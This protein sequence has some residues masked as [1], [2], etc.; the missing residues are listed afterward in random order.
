MIKILQINVG[1]RL[2]A[3]DLALATARKYN[4]DVL[5]ISEQNKRR[6]EEERWYSDNSNKAAIAVVNDSLA[7]DKIGPP[8]DG[9]RWIK[10]GG[11][12]FY[13]CY[14]SPNS[15]MIEYSNFIQR[16]EDSIRT[17]D[18]PIVVS[19][20]FNAHS[21][22][23]GSPKEDDRGAI[24]IDLIAANNLSV[25]NIG[26]EPTFVRQ[27][28]R[29]HIDVTFA[30]EGIMAQI[31]N[32]RVM[33]I[34]SLSLHRYISFEI[35]GREEL[36]KT[37]ANNN[38]KSIGWQF[39]K[40]DHEKLKQAILEET[41]LEK[42][43]T[44]GSL[45][46]E[47]KLYTEKM[48][49]IA[50]KCMPR[51]SKG[52]NRPPVYWWSDEI[53]ALR[54]KCIRAKRVYQHKR[55]KKN[56]SNCKMEADE[57]KTGKKNLVLAIKQAKKKCWQELCDELDKD[58]WGRPYKIVMRKLSRKRP[59]IGVEVPGRLENIIGNLFPKENNR[60]ALDYQVP[61]NEE[62]TFPCITE[63]EITEELRKLPNHKT[64]GPDGIQNELLKIV[65]Q[66]DRNNIAHIFNRCLR[67]A[68][69]PDKWKKGN[70][71]L[72]QK[73]GRNPEDSTAYRPL[74]ML[75]TI[76]KLFEKILAKRLNEHLE[77]T[78]SLANTQ[79]GFRRYKSTIDA[80][81]KVM[82]IV[83]TANQKG[84]VVGMLT[85]DVCNAFNSASWEKILIALDSMNVPAYL[86]R[87]LRS[88]LSDRSIV[89]EANGETKVFVMEKG[90]PQ[91]SV[92]G[93]VLWNIMYNDL[94][95]V[96]MP[97][98]VRLI[99]YADDVA[100]LTTAEH[101]NFLPERLEP[102]FDRINEWMK[103]NSLT[104]AEQ[105]TGAI[106]F[107]N[108]WARNKMVVR[109]GNATITS[110]KTIKYLGLIL[111]QKMN[112]IEHAN[113]IYSKVAETIRQLGYILPNLGGAKE[114]KRRL[115]GGVAMS[116]MLY[117][118]SCWEKRM[119]ETAWNKLE[120]LQ[121]RIAIRTASAYRSVSYSAI[122]VVASMPPLRLKAK[123]MTRIHEDRNAKMAKIDTI[124]EWQKLW[125]KDTN[126]RWTYT[127]IPNIEKWV[128]RRHGE[129][130]YYLTQFITGHGSFGHYLHRIGRRNDDKCQL[131]G[132]I[133]DT[134]EHAI[135][136]CDA[137]L[138]L[139]YELS[140]DIGIEVKVDNVIDLMLESKTHWR[141]INNAI[142]R[143]MRAREMEERNLEREEQQ[144]MG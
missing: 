25:S 133:A 57:Y 90:V 127:L 28:S 49:R 29:T 74:C 122:A 43:H 11:K 142:G 115:L 109:C 19:G 100:M 12:R 135:F 134:A 10:I 118:V 105:K 98:D 117:G 44:D 83:E 27:N 31:K 108:R 106:V 21:P 103:K 143:V 136:E 63:A 30:S 77:A 47:V 120:R 17:S 56:E 89:Y 40:L 92:L 4:M 37:G 140:E 132:S 64:P 137:W 15:G 69:Y 34:E 75:D 5:V 141:K 82:E 54:E 112:F 91:G 144:R 59:I 39:K 76:G 130:N 80:I 51:K 102:A 62:E 85:L 7:I 123:E 2:E 60:G 88:Y 95:K 48:I 6:N 71:V 128:N 78:G 104:L 86:Q 110:G 68:H 96:T 125:E 73:P 46:E 32:W 113:N 67:E 23:W 72:I 9:F 33:D 79:Y 93:P 121:R 119:G 42:S 52:H 20:D 50:D 13:S 45:M 8:E 97:G 22:Y 81:K 111:D 70:L 99:A 24:L 139:R 66:K 129:I 26:N 38:A 131:C 61:Y 55:R 35:A 1:V 36:R 3:Q 101:G 116:K 94:L 14:C 84:N 87:I 114:N 124:R 16:L 126:G 41:S 18:A 53:S 107:T 65:A 138:N 58:P